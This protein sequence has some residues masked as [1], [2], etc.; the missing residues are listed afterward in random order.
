MPATRMAPI[1]IISGD[2]ELD[3]IEARHIMNVLLV[4]DEDDVRRGLV[5]SLTESG[6]SVEAYSTPREA[7]EK[8]IPNAYQL[9]IMDIRFSA[10]NISGDV[11][12]RKNADAFGGTKVVAFTGHEND[13]Q[14]RDVFEE[15]FLKG[16]RERERLYEYAEATYRARQQ[17]VAKEMKHRIV[18]QDE[19]HKKELI[20]EEARRE[21]IKALK[22]TRDMAAPLVWYKGREYSANELIEE[23]E[24]ESSVIGQAQIQMMADWLLATRGNN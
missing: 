4:E 5:E 1:R 13:I 23:V 16:A 12:I 8:M 21:L 18:D 9:A 15:V 7:A 17:E 3:R 22:E 6:Y 2:D 19:I 20:A 24:D 11:F 10:P 14:Y